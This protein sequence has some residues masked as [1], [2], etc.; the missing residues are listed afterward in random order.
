M[1][2]WHKMKIEFFEDLHRYLVDG[3]PYP[4]V[5][6]ILGAEGLSDFSFANEG[7]RNR[8][9]NVHVIADLLDQAWPDGVP[10][11]I[12]TPEQIIKVS[13]WDLESTDPDLIPYGYAYCRFLLAFRPKWK[14]I[15]ALVASQIYSFAGRVDRYGEIRSKKTTLDIK[16]GEP[17]DSADPQV[18]L[19]AL[20][21]EE[22]YGFTSDDKFALWLKKDGT[23]KIVPGNGLGLRVGLAAVTLYTFRKQRGLFT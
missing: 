10:P 7:H 19:Y 8:G 6:Q 3:E 22:T 23:F 15:E 17:S 13:P 16:S 4:S 12:T 21:L 18:C 5:T 2:A 11:E 9:T 20:A 1:E 14:L